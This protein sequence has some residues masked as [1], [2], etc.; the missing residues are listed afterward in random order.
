VTSRIAEQHVSITTAVDSGP[1]P[2]G[3]SVLTHVFLEE[4]SHD[5]R[6]ALALGNHFLEAK[7]AADAARVVV[8]VLLE[9][10]VSRE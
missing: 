7:L 8:D 6:H 9:A 1:R 4:L 3:R 2:G 10:A 5:H